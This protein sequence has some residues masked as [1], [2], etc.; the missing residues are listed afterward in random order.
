MR[1]VG[2]AGR[3]PR[4]VRRQCVSRPPVADLAA[5]AEVGVI[6]RRLFRDNHMEV[7]Q[8]RDRGAAI[9]AAAAALHLWSSE[10]AHSAS[11]WHAPFFSAMTFRRG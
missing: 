5:T 10:H 9:L 4:C 1:V 8:S 2:R 7:V 6:I 3:Q 11:G